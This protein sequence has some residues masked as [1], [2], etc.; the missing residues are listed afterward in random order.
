MKVS[1]N[2]NS[3]WPDDVHICHQNS[4]ITLMVPT[5]NETDIKNENKS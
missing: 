4:S 2:M 3:S 5:L 1:E